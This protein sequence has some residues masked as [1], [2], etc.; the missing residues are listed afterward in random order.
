LKLLGDFKLSSH[1]SIAERQKHVGDEEGLN[2]NAEFRNPKEGRNPKADGD[3]R[4]KA[5][6]R[7]LE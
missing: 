4:G 3:V 7:K 5:V 6:V 2:P 1:A